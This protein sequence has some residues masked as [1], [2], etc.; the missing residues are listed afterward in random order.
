MMSSWNILLLPLFKVY[1]YHMNSI[2]NTERITK[3][4]NQ[5][6]ILQEVNMISTDIAYISHPL[7]YLSFKMSKLHFIDVNINKSRVFCHLPHIKVQLCNTVLTQFY[8]V[9][10]LC[11]ENLPPH[12]CILSVERHRSSAH[13]PTPLDSPPE[14]CKLLSSSLSAADYQCLLY[15][16]K[17][18]T[19]SRPN[20]LPKWFC[21]CPFVSL[22]FN[23]IPLI[24]IYPTRWVDSSGE[25]QLAAEMGQIL[26]LSGTSW[27]NWDR[28]SGTGERRVR[29]WCWHRSEY[30]V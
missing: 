23:Q 2:H 6:R 4:S 11:E 30:F 27:I 22:P 12:K 21:L 25:W 20:R 29:G 26:Y 5:I 13:S 24:A 9:A 18:A 1:I 16:C 8:N 3:I 7:F 28:L 15:C 19:H 17:W 10:P 14:A